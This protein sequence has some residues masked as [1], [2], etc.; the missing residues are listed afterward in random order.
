MVMAWG[1][2]KGS[3]PKSGRPEPGAGRGKEGPGSRGNTR[4]GD[5]QT[6]KASKWERQGESDRG[7]VHKKPRRLESHLLLLKTGNAGRGKSKPGGEAG[8]LEAG[9]MGETLVEHIPLAIHQPKPG[10]QRYRKEASGKQRMGSRS[11]QKRG[12]SCRLMPVGGG[13]MARSKGGNTCHASP[14]KSWAKCRAHPTT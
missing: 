13:S 8:C 10:S 7:K 1:E 4:P 12:N 5:E 3:T 14:P 11:R 9:S 2:N 6:H